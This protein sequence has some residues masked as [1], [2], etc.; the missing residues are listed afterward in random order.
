MSNVSAFVFDAYG[1]LFDVQSV[2]ATAEA[3]APRQ[4]GVLS[5]IWR[6]KQLEYSWLQSIML[7]P[8]TPRDDFRTLTTKALDYALSQL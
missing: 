1:T 2:T 7:S 6:T 4:G 3:I 5:Q 8:S